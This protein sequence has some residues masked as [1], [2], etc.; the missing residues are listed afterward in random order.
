[1]GGMACALGDVEIARRDL[2]GRDVVGAAA[3]AG[4]DEREDEEA[5]HGRDPV[6]WQSRHGI[7]LSEIRLRHPVGCG[8]PP[9]PPTL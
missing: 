8:L 4:D 6:G 5:G 9:T 7:A 3:A 2:L 1:M